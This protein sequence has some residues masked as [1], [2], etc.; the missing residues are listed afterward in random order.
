[1]VFGYVQQYCHI[2]CKVNCNVQLKTA[3]LCHHHVRFLI[4]GK[5]REQGSA[6]IAARK[7]LFSR[8]C[9]HFTDQSGHSG[10]SIGSGN[11]NNG[12]LDILAGQIQLTPDGDTSLHGL[13]KML[14]CQGNARAD[15]NQS[16]IF[17]GAY[18]VKPD[19]RLDA[20]CFHGR[21]H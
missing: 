20:N 8:C 2:R 21:F 14:P 18:A 5:V 12:L 17:K 11:G 6:D 3:H 16:G 7:N 13:L 1:M 9:E 15:H 4:Q 10:L 19:F